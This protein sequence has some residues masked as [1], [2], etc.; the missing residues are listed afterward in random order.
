MGI[1]P[2]IK[3]RFSIVNGAIR[4]DSLNKPEFGA[5]LYIMGTEWKDYS[6]SSDMRII[7]IQPDGWAGGAIYSRWESNV[8]FEDYV[9]FGVVVNGWNA[10]CNTTRNGNIDTV[11]N[12]K[13]PI[14]SPQIGK[15]YRVEIKAIGNNIS[16]YIDN[17]LQHEQKDDKHQKGGAGF[18]ALYAIV[19][20][21]NVVIEGPEIPDAGPSGFAVASKSKIAVTWG[22]IRRNR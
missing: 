16:F 19:E 15:W 21:D 20:F 12:H 10:R 22:Q 11:W 4:L 9:L 1:F 6:F 18:V 2:A 14:P 8:G 5:N 13:L 7:E 3:E 17:K